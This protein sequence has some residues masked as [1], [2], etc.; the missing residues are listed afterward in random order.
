[1]TL[2]AGV[3]RIWEQMLSS[4]EREMIAAALAMTARYNRADPSLMA[5]E[6]HAMVFEDRFEDDLKRLAA[7]WFTG[8]ARAEDAEV[9]AL[10]EKIP[11][12]RRA[13]QSLESRLLQRPS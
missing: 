5:R 7:P 4:R 10:V 3:R 1:V 6:F 8:T 2:K 13:F 9:K 11:E 12:I